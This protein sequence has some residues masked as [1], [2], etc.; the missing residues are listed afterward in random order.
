MVKLEWNLQEIFISNEAFYD[1]IENIKKL[2]EDI[3]HYERV[4]FDS[5]LLLNILDKKWKIKELSN[6]VLIYGS[7]MYYKNINDNE[8]IELKNI[9]ESFNNEVNTTLK[10]IDRKILDL[11]FE[12]VSNFIIENP[13]LTVYKLSLHN[14]FRLKKHIQ[15]NVTNLKIKENNNYINEQLSIYDNLLRDIEYKNININ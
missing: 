1:E 5:T 15:S 7:L 8:C 11:G 9:A 6:K 13:K 4:K 2:L 14:L 12:T 10:F 3:K